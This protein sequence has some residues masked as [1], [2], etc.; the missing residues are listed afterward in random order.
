MQTH[1]EYLETREHWDDWS[2][3]PPFLRVKVG[4]ERSVLLSRWDVHNLLECA[5][6][7]AFCS[8]GSGGAGIQVQAF[9]VGQEQRGV[10]T[11]V[12][13]Q[14]PKSA[15][16]WI[17]E[18]VTLAQGSSPRFYQA[19]PWIIRVAPP[20]FYAYVH[21]ATAEKLAAEY[22]M[23]GETYQKMFNASLGSE[24]R[25]FAALNFLAGLDHAGLHAETARLTTALF[26]SEPARNH[27][28][29]GINLML[30]D[31][32][33]RNAVPNG[34]SGL[35]LSGMHPMAQGSTFNQGQ[36]GMKGGRVSRSTWAQETAITMIW[37]TRC[38]VPPAQ[39][40]DVGRRWRD[41]AK[42]EA[43]RGAA[44]QKITSELTARMRKIGFARET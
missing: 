13:V 18:I 14:R 10:A 28:C 40:V 17:A 16:E 37:L 33:R 36:V 39:A 4:E 12:T 35:I 8:P 43:Y 21:A 24:D 11:F 9:L 30:L 31:L 29:W 20:D 32:L 19:G 2:E 26:V 27:R 42:G 41:P 6:E 5:T 34:W 7:A 22:S 15:A 23:R 3:A 25:T 1:L 38:M 44:R